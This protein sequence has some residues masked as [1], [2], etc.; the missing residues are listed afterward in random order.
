M[1]THHLYCLRMSKGFFAWE[2]CSE[3]ITNTNYLVY[4]ITSSN[5]NAV[6]RVYK[7]IYYDG[8]GTENNHRAQS[9]E[10]RQG[11]M[12]QMEIV[13]LTNGYFE[14]PHQLL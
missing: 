4:D 1:I 8:S 7:V 6:Y 5:V 14:F 9:Y 11:Y 3:V 2:V 12:V 13:T 10:N